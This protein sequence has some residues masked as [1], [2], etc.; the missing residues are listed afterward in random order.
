MIRSM[1]GFGAALSSTPHGEFAVEIK[2]VNNRFLDQNV[3]VPRELNFLEM[4][5]REVVKAGIRRGKADVFIRW[6]APAGAAPLYEVNGALLRHYADGVRAA[7]G[8]PAH[9][10][11]DAGA[12]LQ[13]PGTVSPTAAVTDDGALALAAQDAVRQA[14][15][16][17]DATRR[18]EGAK[19]AEAIVG[20]L[21]TVEALCAEI[22]ELKDT[23]V[24]EVASRL[25]ER[26]DQITK[27]AG[28]Q[29]D[30]GRAEQEVLVFADKCD[31]TEEL[32][33]LD[34]HIGSFRK[35][36]SGR[37]DEGVGKAMDFLVQE[38]LREANT[39]GNKARGLEVAN[40][41]VR[42]KGEIEKI[43]EQVQN[44]E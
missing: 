1:T 5:V 24:A 25:R 44:I 22:A 17:L 43:R 6:T 7:L 14:L 4:Q 34:A 12:L 36:C 30:P 32:V 41:V 35:L 31:I 26:M 27:T 40:R 23:L 19:L 20:T 2:T 21:D 33:R 37:A 39:I 8:L 15:D 11:V 38:L 28:V 3:R 18:A 29:P 13:L 16:A 10:P 42:M 9:A